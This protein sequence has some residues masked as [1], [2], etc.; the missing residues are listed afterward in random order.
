ML[1]LLDCILGPVGVP[2][3]TRVT[4]LQRAYPG[5]WCGAGY[6]PRGIRTAA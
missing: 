5:T 6:L 4:L 1:E 2:L 3:I